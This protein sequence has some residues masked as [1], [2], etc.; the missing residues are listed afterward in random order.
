MRTYTF[1]APVRTQTP[2]K[3]GKARSPVERRDDSKSC[4][5]KNLHRSRL[6]HRGGQPSDQKLSRKGLHKTS[7]AALMKV[8]GGQWKTASRV[9]LHDFSSVAGLAFDWILA[10]KVRVGRRLSPGSRKGRR[11]S[12]ISD[13]QQVI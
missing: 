9:C 5:G 1:P 7:G 2:R 4:V 11:H 6:A 10:G 8:W 13:I 3:A 12:S